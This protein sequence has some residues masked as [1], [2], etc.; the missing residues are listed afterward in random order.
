MI[1]SAKVFY[2]NRLAGIL[3]KTDS[4]YTFKYDIEYLD[5]TEAMPISLTFPLST[6]TY[7]DRILFP[8]FDGL[9]PEGWLLNVAK[10]QW[11]FKGTD[12]FEL[13]ATLCEDTIGAVTVIGEEDENV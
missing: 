1:S 12:R 6:G 2:K 5:S 7:A 11:K 8:F 9:I 4:G 10:D 13:L 3:R